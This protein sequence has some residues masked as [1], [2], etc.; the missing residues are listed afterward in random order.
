[1]EGDITTIGKL[2]WNNVM[3]YAEKKNGRCK[4]HDY[5]YWYGFNELYPNTVGFC[6]PLCEK[7]DKGKFSRRTIEI[8]TTG[9]Y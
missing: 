8:Y 9:R 4:K 6:C 1:M 7:Y 2:E 3:R 5:V